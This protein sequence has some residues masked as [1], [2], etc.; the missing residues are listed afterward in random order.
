MHADAA[1]RPRGALPQSYLT[2]PSV[3]RSVK[4]LNATAGWDR[5]RRPRAVTSR[6][7]LATHTLLV[8]EP[9]TRSIHCAAMGA[10]PLHLAY[11]SD[12]EPDGMRSTPVDNRPRRRRRPTGGPPE[13]SRHFRRIFP[14]C[15]TGIAPS[16][17]CGTGTMVG[18]SGGDV[19]WGRR[20]IARQRLPHACGSCRVTNEFTQAGSGPATTHAVKCFRCQFDKCLVHRFSRR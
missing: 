13:L 2:S 12:G 7:L 11:P 10:G 9:V 1:A 19:R 18:T 20:L 16:K 14:S 3:G 5:Y 6:D 8:P 15:S 4:L 17:A